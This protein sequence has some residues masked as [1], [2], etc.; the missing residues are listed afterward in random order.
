MPVGL[1]EV[2]LRLLG[3]QTLKDKRSVLRGVLARARREFGV[4]AAELDELDSPK[5]AAVGF[6][7][8]SNDG[9]H[10]DEVLMKLLD[11]LGGSRDYYVEG[12]DLSTL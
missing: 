12:Y 10:S 4:S 2:R 7:Y 1:L 3:A 9:R 6:A 11:W 5:R 8:L